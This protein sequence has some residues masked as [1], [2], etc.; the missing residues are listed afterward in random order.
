MKKY[1]C[2]LHHIIS[3]KLYKYSDGYIRFL[4]IYVPVVIL[5]TNPTLNAILNP[6]VQSV[7]LKC[8]SLLVSVIVYQCKWS[9][10]AY[11][12]FSLLSS[13]KSSWSRKEK[14]P[15]GRGTKV[16]LLPA[17]Y[18]SLPLHGC[19]GFFHHSK[20]KE[21]R[22]C[23]LGICGMILLAAIAHWRRIEGAD[24]MQKLGENW[25]QRGRAHWGWRG[26]PTG[27]STWC[28]D[29]EALSGA[30]AV[31]WQIQGQQQVWCDFHQKS[32]KIS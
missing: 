20:T 4:K 8:M 21:K 26:L 14:Q 7:R 25:L 16:V 28:Q 11:S 18:L 6:G 9:E 24:W 12:S 29:R 22:K 27:H 30:R 32:N 3:P 31:Y 2:I 13:Q 5:M 10:E 17:A 1:M 23:I 15:T 19:E